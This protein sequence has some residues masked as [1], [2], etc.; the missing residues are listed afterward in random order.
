[1]LLPLAAGAIV[2]IQA[3]NPKPPAASPAAGA[4]VLIQAPNPT[5]PAVPLA[6]NP[7]IYVEEDRFIGPAVARERGRSTMVF[8]GN[9]PSSA[10][11]LQM[12]ADAFGNIYAVGY[13]LDSTNS[14]VG[15]MREKRS[16]QAAWTTIFESPAAMIQCVAL[17]PKGDLYVGVEGWDVY[18]RPAGQEKFLD[19]PIDDQLV[20]EGATYG[21]AT[22]SQANVYAVGMIDSHWIVRK[23]TKGT[24]AFATVDDFVPTNSA[25]K[26]IRG[27]AQRAMVVEGQGPSR[28]VYVIGYYPE[29]IEPM[30][31]E[32]DSP[33]IF[34]RVHWLVRKSVND[35]LNWTTVDNYVGEAGA[36]PSTVWADGTGIVYVSGS[37]GDHWITRKSATGKLH[38]WTMDNDVG[39]PDASASAAAAATDAAGNAYLL[40]AVRPN[41]KD[42]PWASVIRTNATGTWQTMEDYQMP[43]GSARFGALAMGPDGRLYVGGY[44]SGQP[45]SMPEAWIVRSAGPAQLTPVATT[46]PSVFTNTDR[47]LP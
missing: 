35:G 41:G 22:D 43:P 30:G 7:I 34:D 27:Y 15:L 2:L 17:S 3:P 24:G 29:S 23:Q 9:P 18:Q 25:G 20:K 14:V 11:C 45:N 42:G 39:V 13:D 16:G 32:K 1:L 26:P 46:A 19:S 44:V 36:F 4:I 21:L 33:V 28:G 47:G 37:E 8:L 10:A 31:S 6:A 12:A 40:G 38:S 5:P